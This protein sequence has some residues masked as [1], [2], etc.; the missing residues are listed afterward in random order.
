MNTLRFKITGYDE[1]SHSLLVSFASDETI[2][3]DPSNYQS[4]AYQPMTMWPDITNIDEIKK[5]IAQA[6]IYMAEQQKIKEQFVA[7]DVRIK[8]FKEM[9]GETFEF[10][11][12]DITTPAEPLPLYD[13][14]VI[15]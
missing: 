1:E 6:G 3:Q 8:A 12:E 7:D 13:N 2:S 10:K 4:Y 9:I 15:V 11:I 5:R 14:E